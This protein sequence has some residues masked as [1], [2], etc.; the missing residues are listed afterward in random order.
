MLAVLTARI[1]L[2]VLRIPD[3]TYYMHSIHYIHCICHVYC[4]YYFY[5]IVVYCALL[6]L[7]HEWRA[8]HRNRQT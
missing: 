3:C 2:Y 6:I 8:A 7:T 5:C 4:A 1:Q